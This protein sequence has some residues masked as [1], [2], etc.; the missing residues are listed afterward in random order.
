MKKRFN[1]IILLLVPLTLLLSGCLEVDID[2]GIDTNFTAYLTYTITV[3][4]RELDPVNQG[5]LRNTLHRVGLHY[6]D[7]LGFNVQV[8]TDAAPYSL[9]MTRRVSNSNF[10][11]AY[12]S[13]KAMLT[14]EEM[15]L[16]MM[17]DM[18]YGSFQRQ[19]RYLFNAQVDISQIIRLS[20]A[21]ELPPALYEH[22]ENAMDTGTGSVTLTL[23]ASEIVSSS[24]QVNVTDNTAVMTV[25]L[26]FSGKT[27]L[28]LTGVVNLLRDG[29]PG[30]SLS[31]IISN[32]VSLRDLSILACGAVVVILLIILL[33]VIL[34]RRRRR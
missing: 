5:I 25:P 27:D 17:V 10:E 21:V 26:S 28:E 19:N 33:I 4:I 7:D 29:T 12:Q 9:I 15:T 18:A 2:T 6:Q 14:D 31:E 16:F 32:Q 8:H 1:F 23:P 30:G 22:L 24:H 3:D 13:L 20:N 34:V 11:Q